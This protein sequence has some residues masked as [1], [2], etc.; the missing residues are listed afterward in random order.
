MRWI[1]LLCLATPAVGWEFSP[2]PICTLSHDGEA[3]EV[4]LTY[5]AA[6]PEYAGALEG[7]MGAGA[8]DRLAADVAA[9]MKD[10]NTMAERLYINWLQTSAQA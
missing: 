8:V 3:A 9:G 5:D 6:I 4:T 2:T 1:I 10:F 7:A